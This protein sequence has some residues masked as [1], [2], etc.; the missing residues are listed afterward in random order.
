MQ[1]SSSLRKNVRED[2]SDLV[3]PNEL[4]EALA[5]ARASAPK[6]VLNPPLDSA[7]HHRKSQSAITH[8]LMLTFHAKHPRPSVTM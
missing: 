7:T 5:M 1:C 3:K 6:E 4:E 2:L 8:R